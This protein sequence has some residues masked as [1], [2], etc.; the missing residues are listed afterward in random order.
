MKGYK[1]NFNFVKKR[2]DNTKSLL[3]SFGC[4]QKNIIKERSR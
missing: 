3:I 4:N 2:L 1:K